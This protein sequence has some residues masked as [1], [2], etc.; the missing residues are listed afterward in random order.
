MVLIWQCDGET[1]TLT[2]RRHP[3]AGS[4]RRSHLRVSGRVQGSRRVRTTTGG[5]AEKR[6]QRPRPLDGR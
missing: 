2:G 1:L 3:R 6:T 4:R 5:D